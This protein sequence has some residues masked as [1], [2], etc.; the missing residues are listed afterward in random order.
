LQPKELNALFNLDDKAAKI[1]N[2]SPS[3]FNIFS[4]AVRNRGEAED[5]KVAKIDILLSEIENKLMKQRP[6]SPTGPDVKKD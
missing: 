4:N 6:S 1:I 2:A 3:A 5:I